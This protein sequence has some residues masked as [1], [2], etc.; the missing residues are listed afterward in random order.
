M[1]LDG[2]LSDLRVEINQKL[3]NEIIAGWATN[4]V[5]NVPV[6]VLEKTSSVIDR[7]LLP[8]PLNFIFPRKK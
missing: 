5:I 7:L 6:N 1:W 2:K 3:R 4:K 8:N